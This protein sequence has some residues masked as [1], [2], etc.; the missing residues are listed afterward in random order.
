M[1]TMIGLV[2]GSGCLIGVWE[3][4]Q[5]IRKNNGMKIGDEV[6]D[7]AAAK[8]EKAL[9]VKGKTEVE[10]DL[11]IFKN[12]ACQNQREFHAALE[13]KALLE[14]NARVTIITH[15]GWEEWKSE[16]EI[17]VG[18][19]ALFWKLKEI[20]GTS[21]SLFERETEI[22]VR[23]LWNQD[24][25]LIRRNCLSP[26]SRDDVCTATALCVYKT[27][28]QDNHWITVWGTVQMQWTWKTLPRNI[29]GLEA[30]VRCQAA[31]RMILAMK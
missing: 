10:R 18:K 4:F 25:G 9:S 6:V 16:E 17:K 5:N 8:L 20:A 22:H 21:S 3:H 2:G 28:R 14:T 1:V 30:F 13:A 7:A 23:A 29:E 27:Q 24:R 31:N 12:I 15:Q 26:W 11:Q 19:R